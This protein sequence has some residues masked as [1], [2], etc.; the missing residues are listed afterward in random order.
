M[1]EPRVLFVSKPVVPPWHDGSKNLVRD[2]ARCLRV[3]R[4]TVM[5]TREPPEL[6]PRV[7]CAPIYGSAGGF[8]PG[9]SANLRVLTRLLTGDPHDV[10]TF[11]FAPNPAS[12]NA[13]KF[14]I[15]VRRALGWRGKVVQTVASAP[16]SFDG[17]TDLIFG[18]VV[19][20]LSAWMRERLV[21]NGVAADKIRVIPPCAPP[22][23]RPSD[24]DVRA[25]RQALE[26]RAGP[27][28]VYPGDYEVSTGAE[29]LARASGALARRFPDMTLVFACRPKTPHAKAA[30]ARVDAIA[31]EAAPELAIRHAGELP[32]LAPLLAAAD[33]VAFPVD[34][35]YGKVDIPLVVIEAMAIGKAVVVASGGPLGELGGVKFVPPAEP[36]ALGR[37][38]SELLAGEHERSELGE[39]AMAFY[40][41]HLAPAVVAARYDELYRQLGVETAKNR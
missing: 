1:D 39:A 18:D 24:E 28:V 34:E 32:S 11:V 30:E 26:L 2:V 17:V 9:L 37:M 3:A 41:A 36:D 21:A 13:A 14:A 20:V 23:A 35:L 33:V 19:V 27:I 38:I 31:R 25:L 22:P 6:G 15:G 7:Q 40:A 12:S 16:K 8:A 5:T 10:W 29:T 4:P